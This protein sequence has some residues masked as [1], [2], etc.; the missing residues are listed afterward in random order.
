MGP[1]KSTRSTSP[2]RE[3][4]ELLAA[5]RERG[6]R[7]LARNHAHWAK[8]G[9]AQ[10][11]LVVPGA[12]LLGEH[13]GEPFAVEVDPLIAGT[14]GADGNVLEF[15]GRDGPDGRVDLGLAVGER[16]RRQLARFVRCV[17]GRAFLIC[18]MRD[19]P[20]DGVA[21]LLG[22]IELCGFGIVEVGRADE[23]VRGTQF[24]FEVMKHQNPAAQSVG[25]HLEA[26]AV[27]RER[28]LAGEPDG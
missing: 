10:V 19:G 1:L 12:G 2:S 18:A 4:D 3:V 7:G 20:K 27:G 26:R 16:N 11:G 13:A 9:V 23:I 28:I 21:G 15:I 24:L 22:I 6:H 14:L 5:G 25:S 8:G 17:G